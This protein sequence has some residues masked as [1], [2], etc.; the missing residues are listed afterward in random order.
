MRTG[1]GRNKKRA[2]RWRRAREVKTKSAGFY[3]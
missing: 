1:K 2:Q 3:L